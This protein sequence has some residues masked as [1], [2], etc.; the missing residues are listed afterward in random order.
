MLLVVNILFVDCCQHNICRSLLL[1]YLQALD[2]AG[3]ITTLVSLLGREPAATSTGGAPAGGAG[4]EDLENQVLQCMFY[5]CRIS[6][7]RQEKAAVAGL[8]PH[9]RR[10]V[11]R[12]G[13]RRGPGGGLRNKQKK[14]LFLLI[15]MN[16]TLSCPLLPVFCLIFELFCVGG[17]GEGGGGM[18]PFSRNGVTETLM[19]VMCVFCHVLY[20][21]VCWGGGGG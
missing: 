21:C 17:A 12:R 4:D 9:L 3:A 18:S 1:K 5:L 11:Y 10:R 15:V 6:R 8:I 7:K 16:D 20:A 19:C 13:R 14:K 2:K